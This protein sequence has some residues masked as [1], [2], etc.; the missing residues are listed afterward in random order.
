MDDQLDNDLKKRISEVFENFEDN[1]ADEGWLELRKKF[2]EEKRDRGAFAWIWWGATAALLLLFLGI[3]IWKYNTNRQPKKFTA[4][5]LKHSKPGNINKHKEQPGSIDSG[6]VVAENNLAKT[7]SGSKNLNPVTRNQIT[8][9]KRSIENSSQVASINPT[10]INGRRGKLN[11]A[12]QNELTRINNRAKNPNAAKLPV[13]ALSQVHVDTSAQKQDIAKIANDNKANNKLQPLQ[14]N[15]AVNPTVEPAKPGTIVPKPPAK[16]INSMFANDK[17]TETKKIDN[18]GKRV[19]FGVYA[20]TYFNY[21]KGS[22][23][24]INVG[25]G[26]TSDIKI[27]TNLKIV[28]GITIAQNSLSYTGGNSVVI[29][30]SDAVRIS[31]GTSLTSPSGYF[32]TASSTSNVGLVATVKNYD[33]SLVNLDIPLNLKYEFNPQRGDTYILAG[34]SSG[35]FINETYTS[36]YAAQTYF[37]PSIQQTVGQTTTQ[38]FNSF[39][40]AKMLNVAF[41]VGLPFGKNRLTLE[42]FLKYP[43][44]GL[45]SQDIHFG[46]GGINL[47][48]NFQTS[49]K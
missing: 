11:P 23:K 16:S 21:A 39:Y 12:N 27:S 13:E 4:H 14:L 25:A 31:P 49:K 10:K 2:P 44:G 43:L 9:T 26:V 15:T 20:A 48:F 47:K 24:E 34:V 33:A 19:S 29:A 3:G 45:G 38:S 32:G 28:T 1:S 8:N 40:F 30:Q 22:N 35:T 7:D 18:N 36:Q 46:A 37:S 6:S 42:P 17:T 5:Q 41:G